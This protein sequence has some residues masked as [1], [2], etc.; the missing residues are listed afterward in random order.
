M[1]PPA[2]HDP[3]QA[4]RFR[5]FRL[6]V[7]GRFIVT[8]GEQ[9][10]NVAIGW[11]LYNRTHSALALGFIGLV[12]IV[13]VLL[14]S[15]PA[16]Q[17]ADRWSRKSIVVITQIIMGLA[18][19]LLAI[20]S[21]EQGA[22]LLVYGTLA[23]LGSA[24][25][26]YDPASSSL[27]S[28]TV[29]ADVFANAA[30]WS[31]SSW[32]FAAV[33]GPALGGFAIAATGHATVVYVLDAAS[34]AIYL[35][36]VFFLNSKQATYTREATALRS[37]AVGVGFVW[38]TKIILATITL[39]LFAVLLGGATTLLPI[40]AEN[41]LHV[42]PIGLGW[43]RAAPS[44]GAVV[45]ALSIAHLPPFKNAGWTLLLAVAGFGA[46]TIVF[47]VSRWFP[48]SFAMLV[49]LGGFDNISVV[50]RS[51][52]LLL[53]TP[54]AMRGRISAVNS[55][56]VGSSNQ[57]GGF[58]SGLAAAIFG[59]ILAVVGGGVGTILAVIAVALIWPEVRQLGRLVAT[60]VQPIPDTAPAIQDSSAAPV[61]TRRLSS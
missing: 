37:L 12:Q 11:E 54:D 58:E 51:T 17:I 50:V 8:L 31:S 9:M 53:R 13:P 16:G 5:D 47:G 42:G 49:A 48:L 34:C 2:S 4:L 38:R 6:F 56:F 28:Q 3:Y 7:A 23:L 61:A 19:A 57:L 52:L 26:F 22:L 55:V 43:L 21:A 40:Y 1:S 29:P 20:L 10:L 45:M 39:D 15:L 32:Q 25:A 46:A 30:T 41:I 33:T 44:I 60:E 36:L 27:L 35:G 24:T 59:P 14:F 18:A